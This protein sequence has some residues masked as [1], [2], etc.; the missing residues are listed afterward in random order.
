[1]AS[2]TSSIPSSFRLN[3]VKP[4]D[5]GRPGTGSVPNG[6][7]PCFIPPCSAFRATPATILNPHD[8]RTGGRAAEGTGLLNRRTGYTGTAGSNPALSAFNEEARSLWERAS[9]CSRRRSPRHG[10]ECVRCGFRSG[11]LGQKRVVQGLN[12]LLARGNGFIKCA[13]PLD[14]RNGVGATEFCEARLDPRLVDLE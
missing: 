8:P 7:D 2:F 12:R 5:E 6:A 10:A 9:S 13:V 14:F 4:G 3:E 11:V 1:M